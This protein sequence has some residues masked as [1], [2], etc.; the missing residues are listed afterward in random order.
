MVLVASTLPDQVWFQ[1]LV[2]FVSFNTAIFATL[3]FGKLV[4]RR[5]R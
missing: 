5:R 4:P 1:L 3:A 2:T